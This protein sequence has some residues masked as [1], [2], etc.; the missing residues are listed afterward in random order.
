MKFRLLYVFGAFLTAGLAVQ[1]CGG[2]G[3]DPA[4]ETKFEVSPAAISVPGDGGQEFLSVLSSEDWLIRSDANWAKPEVSSGKASSTASKVPVSFEYNPVTSPR[5]AT[6]TV[7]TLG[8][9]SV[10]IAVEQAAGSGETVVKGIS[11]ADDLL[12]FAKAVN[13]GTSLSPFMTSGDVVLLGDIDASSIKEWTPIGTAASPFNGSFNGKGHTIRNISWTIDAS[14]YPD[15]GL[16]GN[17]KSASIVNVKLDGSMTLSGSSSPINA[18][19]VCGYA[20]GG[21]ISMCTNN[22]SV[23]YDGSASGEGVCVAGICGRFAAGNGAGMMGCTNN[24][25]VICKVACRAAGLIGYNEAPLKNCTNG[26][27]ILA[28]RSTNAAPAWCC[29]CNRNSTD[30]ENNTGKGHVGDYDSFKDNPG[31]AP[32]DAYLNA[33]AFPATKGYP[34]E[35]VNVDC[36][37][38]SYYD[39]ETV[40]SFEP[41]AG[42]KCTRYN[43]TMVPRKVNVLEID[44]GNPAV[45]LSTSFADDCVP[46][47]N[48]N[49]NGNNG[50]NVRETLSQLCA[51]KRAAGEKVVAGINTGFFDSNDGIARGF[52]VEE[53]RPVY[54]NNPAVVNALPN[55]GWAFTVFTDGTA[56]C[57]KKTFS[58]KI[59]AAGS[60]FNWC[61]L[62]DTIMRHTSKSYQINLYDS[63]YRKY[64]HPAKT[65][66]V[67]NLAKDALYVVA[68]YVG[69]PM[70]VNTGYAKATVISIK[71]GRGTKLTEAPYIT[72]DRQVGIALSGAQ[73]DTFY[74]KVKEGDTVE[75]RCDITIEGGIT[76]P[77]HTQNSTMFRIMLDGKDN[78]SSIP[79]TNQSLVS[80]DP[81]TFPV[82]SKDGKK[83]WLVEVDGRQDW[84][85]MGVKAYEMY[86][87]GLKLGGWNMT[88]FDGGGSSTMWAW[89][90]SKSK[91]GL[92]NV[93]C[94]SKGERSCMNYI[95]IKEK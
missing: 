1:S 4:E 47:P 78:T 31:A 40:E 48:G 20:A 15:A 2:E 87:I 54:I 84:V 35:N 65:S 64:P 51:R 38:D 92:V 59:R 67:N 28:N 60:E 39:W 75:L 29:S 13:E 89:N 46:N 14:K 88:R 41:C 7:K 32:S 55:H 19:A 66:L 36:K 9:K 8:G 83:V 37:A 5:T 73:A 49:N 90:P 10:S 76:K 53:G 70:T 52:H 6:L 85:S 63:H 12:A 21:T 33:V 74:G 94:D 27:C 68:E 45:N 42:V 23:L 30:F 79:S 91:G 72:S 22:A 82:V 69:D 93:P 62:N 44:L 77:I 25:N 56:S 81:L 43:C 50:F 17:V 34:L 71:D 24:G 26:G 80:Y 58:G 18:G 16:F 86:R 3:V 95:L 11:N 57:G 61:S